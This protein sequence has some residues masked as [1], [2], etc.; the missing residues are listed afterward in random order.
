MRVTA[1]I[2]GSSTILSTALEHQ[3]AEEMFREARFAEYLLDRQRAARIV[4]RMLQD[5]RIPGH[6]RRRGETEYLPERKVPGHDRE[7]DAQRLEDNGALRRSRF[8]HLRRKD[9]D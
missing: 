9:L 7:N 3:S 1:R 8:D 6:E 5:R 4:R 2:R